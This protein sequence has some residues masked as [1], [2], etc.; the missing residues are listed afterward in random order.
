MDSECGVPHKI[1]EQYFKLD[2]IRNDDTVGHQYQAYRLLRRSHY[3]PAPLNCSSA[4]DFRQL[5][6]ELNLKPREFARRAAIPTDEIFGG[7]N[8]RFS[9]TLRS[10]FVDF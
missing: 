10:L 5:L 3:F 7:L 9:I 6:T 4:K 8:G 1:P 2:E